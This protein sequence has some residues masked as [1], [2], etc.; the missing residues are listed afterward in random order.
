V[1]ALVAVAHGSRDPRSAATITATVELLRAKHSGLDARVAFLDLC[2]PRL[3]DVL[4]AVAGDGHRE[5]VVV[6]LLLGRAYHARVDVPALIAEATSRLPRLSVTTAEVLGTDPLLRALLRRRLAESGVD[7]ADPR[8]GIVLA[9]AGSSHAP[10]NAAV[11]RMA[12]IWAAQRKS[13]VHEA[14]ASAGEPAVPAAIEALRA[15]GA[16]RIAVASWFLAPG[17]LPDRVA[18]QALAA[19]PDAIIAEPLGAAEELVEVIVDRYASAV[20]LAAEPDAYRS[21]S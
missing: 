10:A 15:Q 6:P 14:F 5:A 1:T 18:T 17:L 2:T 9:G 8:L 12:K 19:D 4:A 20:Q 7:S 3:P 13:G 21:V 16:R 11:A